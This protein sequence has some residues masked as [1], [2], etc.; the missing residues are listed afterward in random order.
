MNKLY[1]IMFSHTAPKDQETGTKTY[2]T[3]NNDEQ[4]YN[5][6]DKEYNYDSWEDA[7]EDCEGIE[8]RDDGC[9]VIGVESFKQKLIRIKGEMY[10]EDYDYADSHYGITLYGWKFVAEVTDDELSILTKHG[11]ISASL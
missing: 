10:D 11:I 8:V 6:I 5:F 1:K 7:N 4:V 2:I 9:N 3:A